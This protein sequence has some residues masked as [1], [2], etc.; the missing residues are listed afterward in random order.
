MP[1]TVMIHLMN[2]DPIVAEMETMPDPNGQFLV[3]E[4]PRRRD[5]RDIG[6]VLPEVRSLILPWHRIHCVE[7]LPGEEEE[8]IVTIVRE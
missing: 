5:G 7:I 1:I 2:E 3:C 4:N 6:Y 8:A